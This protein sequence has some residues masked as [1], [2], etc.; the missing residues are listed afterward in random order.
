MPVMP[1]TPKVVVALVLATASVVGLGPT[2]VP[3]AAAAGDASL[4]FGIRHQLYLS[5]FGSTASVYVQDVLTGRAVYSVGSTT[6]RV[7]A[8]N[9]KVVTAFVTLKS[10]SP[11]ARVTTSVRRV[12]GTVYLVG[13]GD[14]DL[15]S[16]RV[17]SLASTTAAQLKGAGIR[18]AAVRVDDSLFPAP[19]NASGWDP[20]W[21]PSEVAPVRALVVDRRNLADTALDAGNVFAA[22]LRAAG[23]ATS[24]V[25][26][27]KAPAS[28]YVTSSTGRTIGDLTQEM[29][30][31]SENDFAEGLLRLAA[32]GRGQPAT[33]TGA[34]TNARNVL[35]GSGVA[36]TGMTIIDGSG[37][38]TANRQTNQSI[39]AVL[40]RAKADA[41]V[42]PLLF[43][44]N[45]LPVAGRSGT[46]VNRFVTT[47]TSCAAGRVQAKTGSLDTVTNIS[48]LAT[49]VDGRLRW[50]SVLVNGPTN[51]GATIASVDRIAAAA[52][53]CLR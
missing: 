28:T 10:L 6:P 5:R 32:I 26:R 23:V 25:A 40:R 41:T 33:W 47:P 15:T 31:A 49:G 20:D 14:P 27:A 43:S 7:P 2:P 22:A 30:R 39:V 37:L 8:S 19:S 21:V 4:S 48:G 38:S 3:H 45:G 11:S 46:L 16:A 13:G 29:V 35:A 52:T 18:T 9:E 12:G 44:A 53:A 51:N 24:S 50:V 42:G 17:I 36:L 1:R 34:R